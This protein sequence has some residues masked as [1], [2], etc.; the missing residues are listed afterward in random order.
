[1][2]P[3]DSQSPPGKQKPLGQ[4]EKAGPWREGLSA[5]SWLPRGRHSQ[6]QEASEIGGGAGSEVMLEGRAKEN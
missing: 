2:L 6:P 4:T 5:P 1:M 3:S